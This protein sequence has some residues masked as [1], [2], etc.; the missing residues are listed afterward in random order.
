MIASWNI[1]TSLDGSD[2]QPRPF[3]FFLS[4]AMVL[5]AG[6]C[7]LLRRTIGDRSTW[8]FIVGNTAY[9]H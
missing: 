8:F 6:S 1:N 9:M 5:L 7:A 3:S 4:L 2:S